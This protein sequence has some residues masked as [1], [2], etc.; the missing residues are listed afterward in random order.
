MP[1]KLRFDEQIHIKNDETGEYE[2]HA[3][4]V[5]PI[6]DAY[7]SGILSREEVEATMHEILANYARRIYEIVLKKDIQL[8]GAEEILNQKILIATSAVRQLEKERNEHDKPHNALLESVRKVCVQVAML[9]LFQK[10]RKQMREIRD[11]RQKVESRDFGPSLLEIQTMNPAERKNW[12]Q[13]YIRNRNFQNAHLNHGNS[14]DHLAG[15]EVYLAWGIREGIFTDAEV[16]DIAFDHGDTLEQY[17]A[18]RER[19]IE[20]ILEEMHIAFLNPFR[21]PVPPRDL[22]Q[23]KEEL[24]AVG[25]TL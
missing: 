5:Y 8:I 12:R 17:V 21:E 11:N 13:R 9:I 10:E 6:F 18:E 16:A 4:P 22:E 1:L 25:M 3:I 23:K 2:I 24:F 15:N 7:R 19:D 14:P 20:K